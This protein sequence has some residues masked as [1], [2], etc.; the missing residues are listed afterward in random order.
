MAERVRERLDTL[1]QYIFFLET[2]FRWK[3]IR[4]RKT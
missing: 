1:P 3:G 4:N 2:L